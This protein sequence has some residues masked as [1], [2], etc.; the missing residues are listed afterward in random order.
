ML[1]CCQRCSHN[2][3]IWLLSMNF[4]GCWSKPVSR[5]THAHKGAIRSLIEVW[6]RCDGT[7]RATGYSTVGLKPKDAKALQE[8]SVSNPALTL[9]TMAI[10][11]F[12]ETIGSAAARDGFL[13]RFLIV[14]STIGRQ[15]GQFKPPQPV[16]QPVIDWANAMRAATSN[17]VDADTNPM[18]ITPV[19]IPVSPAA[20]A[21]FEKFSHECLMLM[22][23]HDEEGLAEMFGRSNEIAMRLSLILALGRSD[24][25]VAASDAQWAIDYVKTYALR[26]VQRL[27]ICMADGEF[28][29]AKK[30]VLN[31]LVMAGERGLTPSDINRRSRLFRGMNQRQQTE[32][33]NSLAYLQQAQQMQFPTDSGRGRTRQAWV[34]I[35]PAEG[36]GR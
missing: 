1:G 25:M 3:R 19:I 34:A 15:V 31:L 36:E 12:W 22:N 7:M 35:E 6:G 11:A 5:T 30:Q 9:L 21:L 8:R 13:N 14:E 32:L 17:I 23:Q 2:P 24:T 28:E 18:A 29:A 10:P 20:M 27:K 33:L 16:P 4:I 26:T